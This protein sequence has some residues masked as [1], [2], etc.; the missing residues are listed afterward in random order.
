V[1]YDAIGG[2]AN[3]VISLLRSMKF[4][5]YHVQQRKLIKPQYDKNL[6]PYTHRLMAAYRD[7][8]YQFM[9]WDNKPEGTIEFDEVQYWND[10]TALI[11]QREHWA[12]YTFATKEI[13]YPNLKALNFIRDTPDEKL[14]IIRQENTFGVLSNKRG[15]VIPLAFTDLVNVGSKE[16]P[17]YFTEKHVE[18]ASLFVV[19]YYDRNGKFLRR[20]VYQET[21]DYEKIYCPDN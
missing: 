10:T 11:R 14:A 18:E 19:I 8:V 1:E 13:R 7:G 9:N 4:G 17:L 15:W 20:E 2:A 12:F 3:N 5:A 21:E 16:E 6:I